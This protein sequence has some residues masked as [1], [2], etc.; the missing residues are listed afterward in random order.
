MG[1]PVLR[2]WNMPSGG[3]GD[4]DQGVPV[5]MDHESPTGLAGEE[6]TTI[7]RASPFEDSCCEGSRKIEKELEGAF[8]VSFFVFP[9]KDEGITAPLCSKTNPFFCF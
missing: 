7:A 3:H 4:L 1:A 5:E 8:W 6:V 9:F 2:G